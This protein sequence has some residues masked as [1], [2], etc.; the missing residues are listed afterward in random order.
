MALRWY[1]L[2]RNTLNLS[3]EKCVTYTGRCQNGGAG[4]K[5]K[6]TLSCLLIFCFLSVGTS[7]SAATNY[8]PNGHR[9]YAFLERMEQKTIVKGMHFSTKPLT[10]AEAATFLYAIEDNSAALTKIEKEELSCLKREFRFDKN[11]QDDFDAH[12]K[13]KHPLL[14]SIL[15]DYFYR[16][17]RNLFS[18]GAEDYSLFLDPVLVREARFAEQ[19]GSSA[20][21]NVFTA[22]NGF[23]MRGTVGGRIG[24]RIDVRDSKE[25]GDRVY[26]E[27]TATTMPGRGFASFKEDSAEFDETYAH[28]T[29]SHGPFVV[30]YG[31]DRTVWGR[32]S[33]G[34]LLLS[35]YGAPYDL[36]KVETSFWNIKYLF[37]T[38][39]LKQYP[40]IARFYYP[41]AEDSPAD[42]VEVQKYISGH[43]LDINL[44]SRLNIGL[45]ETVVFSGR[46]NWSY[47][48]PVMFLKGAEHANGDHD[49]A[50]MGMD[51]R[52]IVVPTV[53][54]YGEM[55]IDDVTT[56]K[57]GSSWYGNKL[58]WQVGALTTDPLR[59]ND[60]SARIEYTHI[61]PWVYTHRYA[62]NSYTH[63]GDV[64]GHYLGPNTE[65]IN[66]SFE[67][68][69]HRRLKVSLDF[70][71]SISGENT[72]SKNVGGD[73]L[74][75]YSQGDS[76]EADFLA[77]NSVEYSRIGLALRYEPAWQCFISL[78]YARETINDDSGNVYML[79]FGLN[80]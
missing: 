63:Y 68:Y 5:M 43:R 18:T 27:N 50:A 3:R 4:G 41:G 49:N 29:Y 35:D 38:G 65:L 22:T 75:G 73:P 72:A 23:V 19:P 39:E 48:N 34:S 47:L 15:G 53:S 79:S 28:V 40:A 67:K 31:R 30:S 11:I 32:G 36:L 52:Y 25:W 77:G 64:L 45:H 46:H 56:S 13:G 80:E 1:R 10:R 62:I 59:L 57:L 69:L 60:S 20:D 70:K 55:L 6:R 54:I 44:G 24:Y 2:Q 17:R 66:G 14:P 8:L 74:D 21:D 42:S 12:D 61:N 37:F 33:S 7:H 51:F 78:A 71:R 76:K 58:A 16:N 9:V 26:P